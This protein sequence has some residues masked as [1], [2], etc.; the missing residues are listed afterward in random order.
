MDEREIRRGTGVNDTDISLS[1]TPIG[2]VEVIDIVTF[3]E[4]HPFSEA[5]VLQRK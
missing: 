2:T 5:T 1:L 4:E 3:S